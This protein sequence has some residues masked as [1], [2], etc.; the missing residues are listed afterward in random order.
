MTNEHQ[1]NTDQPVETLDEWTVRNADGTITVALETP[2]TP[3]KRGKVE[4]EPLYELTL[5]KARGI[6]LRK[7]DNHKGGDIEKSFVLAAS[8]CG[9][10]VA[11]FD[12]M[13]AAD[14]QR[15]AKAAGMLLGKLEN[16]GG[17]S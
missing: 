7:S 11:I 2:V 6:D 1:F 13:D 16:T 12:D 8:L 15:V 10:P 3:P 17:D 14:V 9:Q 5:R 4:P